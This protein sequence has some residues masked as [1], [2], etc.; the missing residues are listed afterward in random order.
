[1]LRAIFQPFILVF[2]SI[3]LM[4]ILILSTQPSY[5]QQNDYVMNIP[6]I[7]KNQNKMSSIFKMVPMHK[8]T[9]FGNRLSMYWYGRSIFYWK[10]QHF[11]LSKSLW[12]NLIGHYRETFLP[13]LPRKVQYSPS[14]G[15]SINSSSK[16]MLEFKKK[17]N[18]IEIALDLT[19]KMRYPHSFSQLFAFY[20]RH[21]LPILHKNTHEAIVHYFQKDPAATP[22]YQNLLRFFFFSIP[23]PVFF[24]FGPFSACA[25]FWFISFLCWYPFWK[26]LEKITQVQRERKGDR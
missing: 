5:V 20:N 26:N 2:V 9:G 6:L 3:G 8:T 21:F 13:Y 1:M 16:E 4:T 25:F 19:P 24:F 7:P 12:V 23:F 15:T 14:N 11:E 18:S 22:F 10:E 17:L